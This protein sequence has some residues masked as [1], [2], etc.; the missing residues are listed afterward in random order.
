[1]ENH[2]HIPSRLGNF[3][4]AFQQMCSVIAIG[5]TTTPDETL[6]ELILQ[7]MAL[8]P[9]EKVANER[10]LATL[11]NTLFGLQIADHEVKYAIDRLAGDETIRLSDAGNFV[12]QADVQKQLKGRI[13]AVIAL[14]EKVRAGWFQEIDRKYSRLSHPE[15]WKALRNYLAGAFLRHGIQAVALLDTSLE[16]DHIYSKSLLDLLRESVK[17]FPEEIQLDAKN[18]ISNFMTAVG[19]Y[20]ERATYIA[21][22]ADGAFSYFSLSSEPKTASR[23]R[24]NL[25]PLNLFLDTNFL[26]GILDLSIGPQVA[27]S[28]ELIRVIRE[29]KFPFYLKRHARTEREILSSVTN[30]E[31]D[32]SQRQWSKRISRAAMTSRFLTGVELRYHQAYIETGIDVQSFFRPFHH[33]DILLDDKSI[34]RYGNSTTDQVTEQIATLINDYTEYLGPKAKRKSY[35]II[36]HDMTLLDSVRQLRSNAKSTLEAGALIIT[37]DYSLYSFDWKTSKAQGAMPCTVLPNLFWQVLRPFIGSDENFGKAFAETFAIPEFRTVNSG[38]AEACSKMIS[39]LSGYK[40]FPEETAVKML[41]NDVLIDQ[42]RKAESDVAFQEF[43]EDA[44]VAEN[45]QLVGENMMLNKKYEIEQAEKIDAVEKL[46][47][48]TIEAREKAKDLEEEKRQRFT[49][50]AAAR[51]EMDKRQA[52]EKKLSQVISIG[53]ATALGMGLVILFEMLANM[54]PWTWLMAHDNSYGLQVAFDLLFLSL[55]FLLFVKEWRKTVLIPLLISIIGII[56]QLLG[57][58]N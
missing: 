25:S 48:T 28:N 41:S 6:R 29:Y 45:E 37:C 1:M 5:Q 53:K 42:L 43:V 33:A 11:L 16:L 10:Q 47:K 52:A 23:L 7:A 36:A 54:L 17:D 30:H 56:V 15:I 26:F 38:S 51:T 4:L 57:G 58:A 34:E 31:I 3:S 50:E 20:P 55:C 12:L 9:E 18:A 24:Q 22:L 21:Q 19:Q 8:L 27:V 49:A 44:I 13:D 32:F 39:I 2:N 35:G 40:N 46:E 14:E